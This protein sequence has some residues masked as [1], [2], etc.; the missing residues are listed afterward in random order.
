[1]Y[2]GELSTS[3]PAISNFKESNEL[4]MYRVCSPNYASVFEF[5]PSKNGG[6]YGRYNVY[7]TYKPYQPFIYIAPKYD[8]LYGED[9]KDNRGLILSGDFSLPII[10]DAWINYQLQNKNYQLAFD[11]QI[12]NME[13]QYDWQRKLSISQAITGTVQGTASGAMTGAL[14]GGG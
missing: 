11:R 6:N 10:S 7:C 1:M 3:G 9:F 4:D 8:S 13:A 2:N 12:E 5:S 14:V